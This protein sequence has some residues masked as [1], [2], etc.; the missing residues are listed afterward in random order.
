VLPASRR[1]RTILI[2]Y[3]SEVARLRHGV[4][5]RCSARSPPSSRREATLGSSCRGSGS[6]LLFWG[7]SRVDSVR[8]SKDLPRPGA[9]RGDCGPY[10]RSS[11]LCGL[12]LLYLSPVWVRSTLH[13]FVLGGS[14]G[15]AAKTVSFWW[16][17][18]VGR[19]YLRRWLLLGC[20]VLFC[21]LGPSGRGSSEAMATTLNGEVESSTCL[22]MMAVTPLG[23]LSPPLRHHRGPFSLPPFS[24][25]W[26]KPQIIG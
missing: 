21:F 4:R 10:R 12:I 19:L 25:F 16:L 2:D 13:A 15:L 5:R 3:V 18:V 14:V 1:R 20:R 24:S 7:S 23:C 11:L 8:V 22:T 17:R 9:G 6:R 26:V